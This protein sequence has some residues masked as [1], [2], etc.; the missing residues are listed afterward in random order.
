VG[1]WDAMAALVH[2]RLEWVMKKLP[3]SVHGW[4]VLAAFIVKRGR[5]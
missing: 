5:Y 3:P 4:N 1:H 2:E